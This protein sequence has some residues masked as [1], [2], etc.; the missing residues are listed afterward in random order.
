MLW[1]IVLIL[2]IGWALGVF[3]FELGALLHLLLIVAVVM[4]ILNLVQGRRRLA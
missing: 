4:L 3:V 1:L 2:L